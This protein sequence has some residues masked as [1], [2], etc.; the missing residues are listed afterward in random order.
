MVPNWVNLEVD[1][2]CS[3][4]LFIARKKAPFFPAKEE[5][6]EQEHSATTAG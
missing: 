6:V 1:L 3:I 5:E 2:F 4:Q